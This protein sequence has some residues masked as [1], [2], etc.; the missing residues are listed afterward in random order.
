[1]PLSDEESPALALRTP[2]LGPGDDDIVRAVPVWACPPN[3]PILI[4][5]GETRSDAPAALRVL[6]HRLELRRAQGLWTFGVTSAR[7][8]EGKSTLAAQLA[9]VLSEAQRASVLLIE[10]ALERPTLARLLGLQVPAGLG[11]SVQI[12]RRMRGGTDP[13]AV[14]ALGP[15]LH[16]LVESNEEPGYAGALYAPAFR[17]AIDRLSRGYDWVI[18]DAPS[19]L[20]S[21]DANVVEEVVDGMIVVTRSRKSRATDLRA[22]V[23]QLGAR[24]A[25]GVVMWDG[26]RATRDRKP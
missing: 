10:A 11:F 3:P 15:A 1:M 16:A 17:Q 2:Q 23:K 19:V 7:D 26:D 4:M 14:L 24:K 18:I 6:R 9:L 20:G 21:G 12:S 5:L 13:W 25:V 22:A 8:G